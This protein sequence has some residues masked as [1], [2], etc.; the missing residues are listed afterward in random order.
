MDRKELIATITEQEIKTPK[1]PTQMKTEDLQKLY[2]KVKGVKKPQ[3]KD[4]VIELSKSEDDVKN[5]VAALEAEGWG[6]R[7][8]CGKV[9]PVYVKM[10]LKNA[11]NQETTTA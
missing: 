8:K 10:V 3:M 4:R 1:H 6:E 11:H 5:I 9:R 2:D 7:M